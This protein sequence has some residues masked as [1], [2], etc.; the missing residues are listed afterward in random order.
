[1]VGQVVEHR[2]RGRDTLEEIPKIPE[3]IGANDV[4]IVGWQCDRNL[5]GAPRINVEMIVPEIAHYLAQR[6]MAMHRTDKCCG[7]NFQERSPPLGTVMLV[8][9]RNRRP[10]R[11]DGLR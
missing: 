2:R 5:L 8:A 1:M 10:E 7:D 3:A 4:A 11:I 9:F 6:I